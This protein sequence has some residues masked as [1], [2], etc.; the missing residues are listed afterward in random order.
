MGRVDV[1]ELKSKVSQW[2]RLRLVQTLFQLSEDSMNILKGYA[3]ENG[4]PAILEHGKLKKRDGAEPI[5]PSRRPTSTTNS[6]RIRRQI[7]TKK[8][9]QRVDD[10][11][12]SRVRRASG[13][14]RMT[15]LMVVS[16]MKCVC[17]CADLC[18]NGPSIDGDG[19]NHYGSCSCCQAARSLF[20]R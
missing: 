4:L 5:S 19:W 11:E 13:S 12:S 16:T 17:S 9:E 1:S 10:A 2:P 15:L 18:F 20:Q 8:A 14:T 6:I 7:S 3:K